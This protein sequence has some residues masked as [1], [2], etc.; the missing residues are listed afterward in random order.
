MRKEIIVLSAVAALATTTYATSELETRLDSMEKKITKLE[1]DLKKAKKT[2]TDAKKLANGDN[3]KWDVN[4]RTAVDKIDYETAKGEEYGN[5]ALLTNRLLLG[6]GY[7]PSDNVIFKGAL[8]YHK[9]FGAAPAGTNGMPQRGYGYDTFD[10]VNAET[11]NSDKLT[12]KEAYWLYM[13]DTFLGTDVSWTASVG[14]R[15]S[16]DG[17]L[18]NMR[19]DTDAQ[20]PLGHI[21]D[22]EFDG[23]SFKFGL[24]KLTDVEGMYWKLC[25]GRGMSDATP[26]FDMSGGLNSYGDYSENTNDKGLDTIDL[27]GFIFVPYSDGQYSVETTMFKA[28]NLPGFTMANGTV[29]SDFSITG[30]DGMV[31][32]IAPVWNTSDGTF[33]GVQGTSMNGDVAMKTMG[34]LSGAAIS[35]K[36]DGLGDGINDFLDETTFFASWA[37][38]KTNPDNEQEMMDL[39][40]FDGFKGYT[41]FQIDQALVGM[42]MPSADLDGNGAID[43]D[44]ENGAFAANMAAAA[45][46]MPAVTSGMLGSTKSQ[47]GSSIYMG[48]QIPAMFTEDGRIGVEYNKGSK[49][50]RSFTYAEDTMAGSKLATRGTAWEVYY[51][52][53]L[54]KSLTFQVRYTSISYDY[55]GSQAFFGDDGTPM[56]MAEAEGFGM[57]PIEKATDLRASITYKF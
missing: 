52:Q 22:V 51:T 35:F 10:W 33:M 5:D 43:S 34:D 28:N 37:Q 46:G 20:S 29:Q 19:N 13:N 30:G 54:M 11:A 6:M 31:G 16:T 15:P 32:A 44:T 27:A 4:L 17:F 45:N 26:R 2:A 39:S 23:A 1:K 49:Y 7:A 18:V 41:S 48:I 56:T 47:T 12:V 8:S 53:P 24:D 36:A 3:I 14:R 42:G 9:V 25:L 50:W 55:T 40:A 38:S 57:D 21:I